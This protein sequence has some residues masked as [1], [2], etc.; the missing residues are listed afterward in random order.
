VSRGQ[1]LLV[2][3]PMSTSCMHG[4]PIAK[5]SH[6]STLRLI[7]AALSALLDLQRFSRMKTNPTVNRSE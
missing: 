5:S 7:T 1:D 6:R 3:Q 4:E 2:T